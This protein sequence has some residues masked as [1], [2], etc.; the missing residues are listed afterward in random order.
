VAVVISLASVGVVA[1][2]GAT[3]SRLDTVEITVAAADVL[4]LRYDV[5]E[6]SKDGLQ[7]RDD[8]LRE[9][10]GLQS[11]DEL[12][13]LGGRKL[14]RETDIR[15]P[16][17]AATMSGATV[18]DVD[19]V[20]Q[21]KPVLVRWKID[22]SLRAA[23]LDTPPSP[24]RP[25]LGTPGGGGTAG[26]SGST[27]KNPFDDP[28]DPLAGSRYGRDPLL[29]TIT[30]IDDNHVSVPRSTVDRVL[31]NPMGFSRG[32]RVVPAIK[33]GRV[34]GFKLY[35]IRP[36]SIF[37]ALN[38]MNGDTVHSINGYEIED[39]AQALEV[40]TKVKDASSL[41]I[42]V[43]RRGREVNLTIDIR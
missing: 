26:L 37:S 24:V 43:I 8:K 2:R 7:L 20:R 29:D 30:R 9:A 5:V 39:T 22:G 32:A 42:V 23:R 21:G 13:M 15:D 25:S 11:G 14:E 27:L 12:V 40:Y 33:N 31:A 6:A 18:I 28:T 41:D 38:L 1:S 36:N 34:D 16:V 19:L 10:L 3:S 17:L 35:A 4:K